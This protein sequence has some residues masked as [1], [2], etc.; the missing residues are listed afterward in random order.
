MTLSLPLL[1]QYECPE[2]IAY[3]CH[4]QELPKAVVEQRFKDLLAWFWLSEHRKQQGKKTALF[5][6]LL[7]LDDL[8]H[9][10]ILHTRAYTHFSHQFFGD[11]YHH[12][13]EPLGEEYSLS[14]ADL[15]DLLQDCFEHLGKEWV[16][17]CFAG[18]L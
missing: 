10:F 6:P 5:G 8:W 17:R 13:I 11:Y 14:E 7:P 16:E 15:R 12:D 18:L 3:F 1:L 4:H 2:V 9:A